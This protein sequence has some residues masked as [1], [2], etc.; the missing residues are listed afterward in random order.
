MAR[1]SR[2]LLPPPAPGSGFHAGSADVPAPAAG[3][4]ERR[5]SC[6]KAQQG[7]ETW[8]LGGTGRSPV[9]VGGA[10]QVRRLPNLAVTPDNPN[11]P[12]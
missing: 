3:G 6:P 5:R 11:A 9:G 10:F 1:R 2:A 8:G 7:W 4:A 12:R